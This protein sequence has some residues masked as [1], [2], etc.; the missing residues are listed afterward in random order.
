MNGTPKS[1][2]SAYAAIH[3]PYSPLQQQTQQFLYLDPDLSFHLRLS[4]ISFDFLDLSVCLHKLLNLTKPPI[5]QAVTSYKDQQ[6]Y[7]S[8]LL[9]A[10]S[11]TTGPIYLVSLINRT[12]DSSIMSDNELDAELLALAGGDGSSSEDEDVHS[13][14]KRKS[15]SRDRADSE[16][17]S[18]PRRSGASKLK[19]RAK[20]R[21]GR[22]DSDDEDQG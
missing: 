6:Y 19:S 11:T 18:P 3:L 2:R 8:L 4:A 14:P 5:S 10:T 7:E 9:P 17:R 22:D 16:D 13:S 21:R 12:C 15:Q 20:A 1:Y